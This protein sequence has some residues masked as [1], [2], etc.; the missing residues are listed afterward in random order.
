M[1]EE[2]ALWL[3]VG[4]APEDTLPRLVLADWLDE[5]G[6]HEE[7]EALRAMA[8]RVPRRFEDGKVWGWNRLQHDPFIDSP[9]EH[10]NTKSNV[11]DQE[12][13]ALK[14]KVPTV[15]ACQEYWRDYPSAL[16]AVRDLCRAWVA[17]R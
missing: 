3:A 15:V 8:D 9:I 10:G 14:G 12:F 1:G 7:A 11:S 13:A 17:T 16:E 4:A 5:H 2:E 6:R